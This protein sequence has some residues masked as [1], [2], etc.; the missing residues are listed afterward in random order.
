[1]ADAALL[2]TLLPVWVA[3]VVLHV[4]QVVSGRL[5]WVPVYVSAPPAGD[6]FPTVRGFWPGTDD[7]PFGLAVGD[8]LL[9][10]G[11]ADLRGVGPF[12]FVARVYEAAA[13]DPAL[14]VSLTY[15]RERAE[16]AATRAAATDAAASAGGA[17]T[18][19]AMTAGAATTAGA[20][21]DSASG[22]TAMRLIPVAFPWRMLPLTF[23]VVV[24]G[25]LVLARQAGTPVARAFFLLA[26]AYGLHWTFFFGGPRA[27]TYAWAV[28]FLTASTV[29]LPLVLRA[30]MIFPPEVAPRSG[31]LPWWPWVF[32][33]FGPI[34]AS[35]TFGVPFP[36]AV[37][38]RAVFVVNV[39]FIATV[40]A[41][42]TRN[43]RRA[44]PVGRR[45]LKWV[46]LG[47]Y[48]GTVPVLLTDVVTAFDPTLWWLHEVAAMAEILIP[49]CV[50]VAIVRANYFDVDHL[51]T[52]TAVY[53][54]L[55]VLLMAA[56]LTIVPSLARMTSAATDLDPR[57]GQLLLSVMVAASL[58]PG[59]RYLRPQ[60]ERLL[61]R[62]R[63]ALKEGVEDLL[64]ELSAADGAEALLTLTGERLADLVRPQACVIYASLGETLTPVFARG[65]E[66]HGG[67][68]ALAGDATVIEALRTRTA[69]LDLEQWAPRGG[70]AVVGRD[71]RMALE[72]LRAAVLLPIHRGGALAAIVSLAHKRSGDV[73]TATDLVL[74]A[75]VADKVSGELLRFDTAEILRQER[76]MGEAMRRYVPEPVAARLSRG[77]AIEGGEREVS[78]LFVDIRGYTTYSEQ[79][80]VGDVF[81]VINR[82]TETVSAVIQRRGGTVVEFLGD[83]LMAVFG[84]PEPLPEHA[85]VAVEAACEIVVAVRDLALGAD[86][87]AP[88][89][90]GVGIATGEAFVGN[91]QTSDRLVY[92]AVGDI[93]NLASRIQGLTRELRAAVA[94]DSATHS[95]AAAAAA[96]FERHEQVAIRGRSERVDVYTL[97]LA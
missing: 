32:A 31:R 41:V 89:A 51:I 50:L 88:I 2:A 83:G 58:V 14:P 24:T 72:R 11:S 35:W 1:V 53:S 33:V 66:R 45:Q 77:Q 3:C 18:T 55:S 92:T 28:V 65:T 7:D 71:E 43:F 30:V 40:L 12:G 4:R 5:A 87:D 56:V 81:S 42:I 22:E 79:Q 94:I 84:A 67:P 90:V 97:P 74:L 49:L 39:L 69:P 16:G 47:F 15:Q 17:D 8:R 59:Q 86:P 57:T 60:M 75:T 82:Y 26:I 78:V 13:Q 70:G 91:I 93:V 34:S 37:G 9:R 73:Y 63:H 20:P 96:H 29:M 25:A 21:R 27:Q 64:H 48:I 62:E 80:A 23:T 95:W 85:R 46:V 36:P 76:A 10:V 19:A 68:P 61:F 6:G 54:F 44:S 38:F 52:G